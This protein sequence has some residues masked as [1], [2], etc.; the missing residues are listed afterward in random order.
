[1]LCF[2]FICGCKIFT[3]LFSRLYEAVYFVL[4]GIDMY[5]YIYLISAEAVSKATFVLWCVF[6]SSLK[7]I[8]QDIADLF[9]G[10]NFSQKKKK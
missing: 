6:R 2:D 8:Y 10:A 5:L 3:F 9:A 7:N 1:M 4:G